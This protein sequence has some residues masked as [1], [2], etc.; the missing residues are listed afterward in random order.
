MKCVRLTILI[1]LAIFAS[2]FKYN[3]PVDQAY[4]SQVVFEDYKVKITIKQHDEDFYNLFKTACKKDNNLMSC[5]FRYDYKE[6]DQQSEGNERKKNSHRNYTEMQLRKH[7][8]WE[9]PTL[10]KFKNQ[11]SIEITSNKDETQQ[12]RNLKVKDHPEQ[13]KGKDIE[14]KVKGHQN[15]KVENY[16]ED[17]DYQENQYYWEEGDQNNWKKKIKII[18]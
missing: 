5:E 3:V 8:A 9:S 1:C 4:F 18:S 15:E 13:E 7:E 6:E 16:Q 10:P 11:K 14:E 12:E 2:S 17:K